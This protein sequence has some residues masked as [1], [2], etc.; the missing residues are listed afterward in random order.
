MLLRGHAFHLLQGVRG[1]SFACL[2]RPTLLLCLTRVLNNTLTHSQILSL[3]S[4]ATANSKVGSR[5]WAPCQQHARDTTL[6]SL[7]MPSTICIYVA[8]FTGAH[9][10]RP[11]IHP[12][13]IPLP[14]I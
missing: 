5:V 3:I 9:V 1:F 11:Y 14:A 13:L 7:L 8:S 10:S 2:W 4:H 6:P 12:L